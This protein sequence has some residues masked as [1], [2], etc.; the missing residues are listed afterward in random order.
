MKV[1]TKAW[2]AMPLAC[3]ALAGLSPSQPNQSSPRPIAISGMLLGRSS[4]P[5]AK[6]RFFIT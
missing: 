2:A 6:T 5:G 3:M 1:L 4:S